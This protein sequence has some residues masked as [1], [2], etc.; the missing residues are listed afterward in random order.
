MFDCCVAIDDAE[1]DRVGL[2]ERAGM[3]GEGTWPWTEENCFAGD[4]A[5]GLVGVGRGEAWFEFEMD[6]ARDGL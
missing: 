3:A 1:F 2:K 5:D 4:G 6:M